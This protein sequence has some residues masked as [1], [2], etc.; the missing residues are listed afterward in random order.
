VKFMPSTVRTHV[1]R[2]TQPL[3]HARMLLHS[4]PAARE[5]AARKPRRRR[6]GRR[7]VRG[8]AG[9]SVCIAPGREARPERLSEAVFMT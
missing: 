1:Q 9:D 2:H 5:A 8:A 6:R 3:M 4:G 7:A